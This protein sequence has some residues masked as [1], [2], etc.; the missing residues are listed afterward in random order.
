MLMISYEAG[1]QQGP[2]FVLLEDAD[3]D[4]KDRLWVNLLSITF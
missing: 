4:R 1:T 2:T 3:T